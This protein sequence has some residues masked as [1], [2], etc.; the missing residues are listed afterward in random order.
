MNNSLYARAQRAMA[1][2][3]GVVYE[4]LAESQS[5]LTNA[6]IGRRLGIYRGHVGHEGH[7]SRTLLALLESEEV[8]VQNGD[9]R[10]HLRD[11]R[12]EPPV[13]NE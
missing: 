4:L 9:K 2:L 3:K 12:G 5:P 1:D 8:I 6:E 7:I 11:L 10:W 13:V